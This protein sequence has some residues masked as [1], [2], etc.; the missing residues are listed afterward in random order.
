MKPHILLVEDDPV[1]R[2]YLAAA[3]QRL[4]ATVDAVDRCATARDCATT[5][6]HDL[7]LIDAH[8][9][10]GSGADLL[11]TLR[12][13][14]GDTPALAHTAS[15]D[16]AT[17]ATLLDAGFAEVLVKPLAMSELQDAICRSLGYDLAGTD[18]GPRPCVTLPAW[19]DAAALLALKGEQAHV[20]ALRRL[21]LGELAGQ[22]RAVENAVSDGDSRSAGQVLHMLRA[23]CGFVGAAQLGEAARVL[24]SDL[25]CEFALQRFM[26]A[27]N[28]LL[29]D[30]RP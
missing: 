23:S 2:A 27:A 12:A 13:A 24:E 16:A 9:P 22:C 7:W 11:A 19:D 17:H 5:A 4:P 14:V 3:A 20:M 15:H 25:R 26:Q 8:L 28:D 30:A 10:D 21:F 1:S 18:G 6:A 29:E